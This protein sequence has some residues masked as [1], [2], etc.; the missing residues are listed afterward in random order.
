MNLSFEVALSFECM[1]AE[2]VTEC[3]KFRIDETRKQVSVV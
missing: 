1:L 2:G 3:G